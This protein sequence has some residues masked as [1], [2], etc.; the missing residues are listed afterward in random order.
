MTQK[1]I[2]WFYVQLIVL[3]YF[4]KWYYDNNINTL[5]NYWVVIYSAFYRNRIKLLYFYTQYFVQ[6]TLLFSGYK[7]LIVFP[8]S[9]L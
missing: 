2:Y 8:S 5:L 7:K 9:R 6:V 1:N 4:Q 3:Q